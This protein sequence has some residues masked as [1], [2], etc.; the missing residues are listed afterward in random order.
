MND[1]DGVAAPPF[2]SSPEPPAERPF[3]DVIAALRARAESGEGNHRQA[4]SCLRA[5]EG[6]ERL[7]GQYRMQ[8]E[9]VK[10]STPVGQRSGIRLSHMSHAVKRALRDRDRYLTETEAALA[11]PTASLSGIGE[12]QIPP[13]S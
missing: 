13:S 7:A 4:E 12:Y 9:G 2:A 11:C 1:H 8:I 6:M 10:R 3:S 5:A